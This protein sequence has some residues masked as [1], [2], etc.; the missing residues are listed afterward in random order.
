VLFDTNKLDIMCRYADGVI[1]LAEPAARGT[2]PQRAHHWQ[3]NLR[4]QGP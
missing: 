1:L 2:Q 4:L 3:P